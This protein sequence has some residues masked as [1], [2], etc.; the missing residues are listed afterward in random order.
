MNEYL[1]VARLYLVVLAIF[2]IGRLLTGF[3]GVPYEKGHHIFSLVTMSLLASIFYGAFCRKWRGYT[4][5]R[6]MG[7]GLTIG[8]IGQSVI[9]LMTVLS[10]ALNV[11]TYFVNPRAL[12]AI[13]KP[14]FGAALGG[15]VGGLV[16]NSVMTAIAAA[17][18]WVL[19]AALPD[20]PKAP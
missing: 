11:D 3:R 6:A 7:L 18:G 8:I 16:V 15:R 14:P 2:T 17:I 12:N 9:L 4:V 1:R 13:E 19:G 5:T 10:Y 20:G